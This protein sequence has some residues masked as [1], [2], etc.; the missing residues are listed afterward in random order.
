MK[1]TAQMKQQQLHRNQ[2]WQPNQKQFV[3]P[4]RRAEVESQQNRQIKYEGEYCRMSQ[5]KQG[6]ASVRTYEEMAVGV[7]AGTY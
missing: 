4:P 1:V 3:D 6:N 2:N 7:L 5:R